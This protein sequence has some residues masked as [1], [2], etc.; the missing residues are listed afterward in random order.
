MIE[1]TLADVLIW[2]LA[3]WSLANVL[4]L[5]N[6]PGDVFRKL[7]SL[8]AGRIGVLECIRCTG[9]WTTLLVVWIS[10]QSID[11]WSLNGINYV[12]AIWAL[13]IGVDRWSNS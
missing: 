8:V 12:L 3:S 10:Q 5:E 1:S 2:G 7:R 9:F 13:V 11:G 6:G 4:T